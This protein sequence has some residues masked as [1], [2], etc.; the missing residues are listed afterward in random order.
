MYREQ[1]PSSLRDRDRLCGLR[2]SFAFWQ[3]PQPMRSLGGGGGDAQHR[4]SDCGAQS[5]VLAADMLS[6]AVLLQRPRRSASVCEA[7]QGSLVW[8]EDLHCSLGSPLPR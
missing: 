1:V 8:Q 6:G 4:L 2:L 5:F 7:T 3:R